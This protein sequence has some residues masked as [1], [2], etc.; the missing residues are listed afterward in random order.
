VVSLAELVLPVRCVA[1]GTGGTLVC[2]GCSSEL[3]VLSPPL[4]GRCGSQTAWPVERCVECAGRRLSFRSA[5]SAVA[6]E[7]AAR[8]LVAGWK[9]RGLRRLA[10]TAADLVVGVV[11]R[12]D[13]AGITF[14]PGDPSRTLWRGQNAAEALAVCLGERWGLRLEPI[15][16]RTGP[17]LRQ[18]GLD[19]R[20]RRAN[21]RGRFRACADAPSSIVLVDDVYTTGATVGAAATELRRAGA[22][23]VDV[24][25]FARAVRR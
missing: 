14:V 5:R 18:R 15:L 12:P 3:R 19:R 16:A 11:P 21:V 20:L 1:C 24:V 25:T 17:A 7:N 2:E 23:A 22:R 9:E 8:R 13:T 6:Y 10:E 4:C